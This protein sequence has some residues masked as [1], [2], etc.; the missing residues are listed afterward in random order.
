[1]YEIRKSTWVNVY[2]EGD[3]AFGNTSQPTLQTE[4]CRVGSAVELLSRLS[5]LGVTSEQGMGN[6]NGYAHFNSGTIAWN[7]V[8]SVSLSGLGE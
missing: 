7:P 4:V 2:R 3:S 6:P 5:E 1:M 8:V